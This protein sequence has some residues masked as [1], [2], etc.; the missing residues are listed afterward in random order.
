MTDERRDPVAPL[1]FAVTVV[2]SLVGLLVVVTLITT[3]AGSGSFMAFGRHA[4]V[5][6]TVRVGQIGYSGG[7]SLNDA[8]LLGLR[9]ATYSVPR[10]ADLCL[11]RPGLLDRVES[12]LG[13]LAGLLLLAG[14]L[15]LTGRVI[16]AAR[17]IRLFTHELAAR[18]RLLGWFLITG[19]LLAALLDCVSDGLVITRATT[20]EGWTAGFNA[21]D[22][23]WTLV[24]VGCGLLS[25]AEVLVR[26]EAMQADLDAVI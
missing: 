18:T 1:S 23:P 15:L 11:S 17:R 21:F 13:D 3:V 25:V 12:S 4:P 20:N 22:M 8:R 19:S 9:P 2:A 24:L 16:R 14:G 5:C 10:T 7:D 26:A 6:T